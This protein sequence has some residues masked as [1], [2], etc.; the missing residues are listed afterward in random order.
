MRYYYHITAEFGGC[1]S[2][3]CDYVGNVLHILL[4][5]GLKCHAMCKHFQMVQ[6]KD[7]CV[8]VQEVTE[9]RG[10]ERDGKRGPVW[11]NVN[12]HISMKGIKVFI[13]RL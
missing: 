12:N 6:Q 10:R 3:Y 9:G 7:V 5:S 13:L 11:R 8:C 1:Y 4:Y 2:L